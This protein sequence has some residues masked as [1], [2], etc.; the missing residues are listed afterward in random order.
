MLPFGWEEAYTSDGL[1]YYIECVQ[2]PR[3]LG[4]GPRT[5]PSSCPPLP[6]PYPSL[7][8]TTQT[9]SWMH[10]THRIDKELSLFDKLIPSS[11]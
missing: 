5:R 7:S 4:R 3:K 1:K 11:V 8:H 9:T 2:E 10:P 6:Y